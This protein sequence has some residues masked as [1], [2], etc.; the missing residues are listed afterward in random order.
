M[1]VTH[2]VAET[3]QAVAAARGGG[4][5]IGLVPTMGALHA[6]HASLIEAARRHDDFIVVTI[7][8]NPT[9]FGPGEDFEKYPRTVEA[10]LQ[11]CEAAGAELVFLPTV[12]TL[13]P[14]GFVTRVHVERLTEHLC[15]PFRPGHF[16]GVATVCAKLFNIV[17]PD[18]AY[19][20][21]KDAQQLAVI[22][23]M[24]RDLDL[25]LEIIGCPTIRGPDGLALSSRN[26][27]L[28]PAERAQA[29]C[30]YRSLCT[31]RDAIDGGE[32]DPQAVV[33]QM[34]EMVLA[35]GPARIAYISLVDPDELQPVARIEG[36]VLIAL[37]VHIG[38]ARLIDNLLVD[39]SR[40]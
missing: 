38:P 12:E 34:R 40:P 22:R 18:H 19:F 13:Y 29:T 26:R 11:R 25:P 7:F 15:G 17:Q 1:L 6:G 21:Q 30:L 16:D 10:D 39:P 27:Y 2:E 28:S 33:R 32:R 5:R 37:A 20:G 14:Q 3:R 4:R 24:V 8:V 35:A 23:R 9:Q 31:A 36:P